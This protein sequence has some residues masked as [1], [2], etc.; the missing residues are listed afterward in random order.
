V[1]VLP[2][3]LKLQRS[4]SVANRNTTRPRAICAR[5][6]TCS[7]LNEIQRAT[8]TRV[9][10]YGR[11]PGC[12][13]AAASFRG[14][15]TTS[16]GCRSSP[17]LRATRDLMLRHLRFS[18]SRSGVV[19]NGA[20]RKVARARYGA[21][22]R[23]RCNTPRTCSVR[24][25]TQRRSRPVYAPLC[26]RAR[27]HC[28]FEPGLLDRPVRGRHSTHSWKT[29]TVP[30]QDCQLLGHRRVQ[31]RNLVLA[32]LRCAAHRCVESGAVHLSPRGKDLG[33]PPKQVHRDGALGTANFSEGIVAS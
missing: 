10:W 16:K 3:S 20:H 22:R 8:R 33:S 2:S 32:R 9:Q 25:P 30:W 1:G 13:G 12:W 19:A 21:S 5:G 7:A 28:V 29:T 23:D 18:P 15:R 14:T 26:A 6:T 17:A 31:T 4:R 11:L 27:S 24:F